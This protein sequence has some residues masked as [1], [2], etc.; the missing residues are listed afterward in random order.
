MLTLTTNEVTEL[1]QLQDWMLVK[2]KKTEKEVEEKSNN[3]KAV[4]H[5]FIKSY[6]SSRKENAHTSSVSEWI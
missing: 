3:H 4:Q 5:F 2:S 6:T 1:E